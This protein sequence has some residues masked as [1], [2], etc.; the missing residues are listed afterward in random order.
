MKPYTITTRCCIT[1][2]EAEYKVTFPNE[3]AVRRS[4]FMKKRDELLAIRE[5]W[6]PFK[7]LDIFSVEPSKPHYKRT[8]FV[9]PEYDYRDEGIEYDFV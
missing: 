7:T 4:F 1:G 3:D 9:Q 6:D 8:G 5:G 2:R